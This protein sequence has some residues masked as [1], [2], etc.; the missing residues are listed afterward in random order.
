MA[1]NLSNKNPGV[2]K[3]KDSRKLERRLGW[4]WGAGE[5]Q[6]G[7]G[8]GVFAEVLQNLMMTLMRQIEAEAVIR[9]I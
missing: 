4:V 9:H 6:I 8:V 5:S 3:R 1:T 7:W 2:L